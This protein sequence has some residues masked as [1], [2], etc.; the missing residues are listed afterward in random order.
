MTAGSDTC[1]EAAAVQPK[2]RKVFWVKLL[3]F[4]LGVEVGLKR[5][6]MVDLERVDWFI[7]G[8]LG[9]SVSGFV[10]FLGLLSLMCS[11]IVVVEEEDDDKFSP[12]TGIF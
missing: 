3:S 1:W 4:F 11:A 12:R 6:A 10:S 7:E 9:G 2:P 5:E 8:K